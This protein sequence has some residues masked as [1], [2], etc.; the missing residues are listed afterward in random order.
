[1]LWSPPHWIDLGLGFM[2]FRLFDIA[3]PWPVGWLDRRLPG[4]W[5]V[6]MDDLAAGLMAAGVLY[7]LK[8]WLPF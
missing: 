5:G 1:M 6:M 8:L 4:A 7:M 3:K 2:L